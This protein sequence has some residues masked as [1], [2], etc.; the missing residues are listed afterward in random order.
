MTDRA[1]APLLLMTPGPTRVPDRVLRAGARPMIHHRTAEFSAELSALIEMLKPVFGT[2]APVLPVHTTGRGALEAAICNFFSAG[3]EIAVCCN[4]KFGEMWAGLAESYGVIAH[5]ACTDWTRQVDALEVARALDAHPG[6]RAVALTWSDTSTGVCNDVAAV[7]RTVRAIRPDVL[8]LVDGVSSIGGM[9]FSFDAWDVDFA[10]TASQ[11]CLMSSPGLSFVAVSPRAWA[12]A[13]RA[14]L[15]S[16]YWD[17]AAIR[18]E[19]IKERP[20]TPGT[21]PVHIVLQ[22]AEALRQMHEEGLERV[23]GRHAQLA[24]RARR[25]AAELGLALQCPDLGAFSSTLTAI[26]APAGLTP[27]DL[28]DGMK[29]RGVLT[30][31]GLGKYKAVAFRIGHMG[32]IR[33]ADVERTMT[34]LAETLAGLRVVR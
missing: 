2:S 26:S 29:A 4:G 22:V 30:A 20:E 16:N 10:A 28:R 3:D 12:A 7:A 9:P 17:F 1:A 19:V 33:L 27:A 6:T 21:P 13:A 8:V 14:K 11:K 23:Y 34:A 24:E 5:R 18:T 31:G 15:P 25:G 32:D